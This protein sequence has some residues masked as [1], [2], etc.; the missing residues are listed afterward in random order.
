[1]HGSSPFSRAGVRVVGLAVGLG[2]LVGCGAVVS[3]SEF[4]GH[5]RIAEHRV[6]LGDGDSTSTYNPGFFD[7]NAAFRA[8]ANPYDPSGPSADVTE[9]C[10]YFLNQAFDPA[11]REWVPVL[12]P[13]A[14][15]VTTLV[16]TDKLEEQ[17]A[18]LDYAGGQIPFAF[19]EFRGAW[20][21]RAVDVT[22]V[23][24]AAPYVAATTAYGTP[25]PPGEGTLDLVMF[26]T[27]E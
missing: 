4:G 7:C 2:F 27:K 18:V 23:P 22:W 3:E 13:D 20:E 19:T 1:M 16:D 26:V 17:I 11:T 8:P 5:W 6:E 24:G 9:G 15:T 21:M 12:D 10:V 14:R 25:A